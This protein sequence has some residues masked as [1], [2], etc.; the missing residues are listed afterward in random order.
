MRACE[1]SGLYDLDYLMLS[2]ACRFTLTP[3]RMRIIVEAFK[4]TL[5]LGLQQP[6][7]VVVC[8]GPLTFRS[9]RVPVF[10]HQPSKICRN[11]G[12]SDDENQL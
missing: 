7:Q 4:E 10:K 5:E 12:V 6:D 1:S 11:S 3:Q 9:Y 8:I 2:C